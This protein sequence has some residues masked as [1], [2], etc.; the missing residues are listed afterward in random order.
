MRSVLRFL[1]LVSLGLVTVGVLPAAASS[2]VQLVV[3]QSNAF[4]ILGHSC[5]GIQEQV[6]ANGFDPSSGYPSGDAYLSTRCGGSGRGGGYHTTTYSA[7]ASATW[8]FG[9][10][11]VSSQKEATTPA[12]D[13]TLSA[14]DSNG[15]EVY[16]SSARAYLLLSDSF[17]PPPRVT[18]VSPSSGAAAGGTTVSI[19]GTGFTNATGVAFGSTAAASFTI[20]S[21]TAITAV[22]P[23]APA[24]TV[25]VTVS[26]A[27]GSSA[28]SGAD[29]FSFVGTPTVTGLSPNHG[30]VGGGNA[31]TITGTNLAAA[32]TVA[33]GDTAAA[34]TVVS[35]TALT[36]T[37]PASEAPDTVSVVVSSLGGASAASTASRYTYTGVPTITSVSPSRGPIAGGTTVTVSGSG[38]SAA[39]A[40]RFGSV[41]ARSFTINSDVSMTVVSPTVTSATKVH[42][43]VVT[44]YGTSASSSADRFTYTLTPA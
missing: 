35:D 6:Y 43:R 16:N 42:I 25:D 24:G 34:F 9:A 31:V 2:P 40:V 27:G 41:A 4:A 28:L 26:S 14:Y 18:A 12:V 22:S 32:T 37:V 19:N 17:V 7:W 21:D 36:A 11:L 23:S 8:D 5:G 44:T 13:P 3:P 10:T 20:N 15:N 29:Q 38:F 30:P 39:T 1:A 33:F